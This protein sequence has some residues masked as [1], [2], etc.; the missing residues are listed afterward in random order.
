MNKK[1]IL[2]CLIFVFGFSGFAQ[3]TIAKIK[4]EEAEESYEKQDYDITLNRLNEAESILGSSNPKTQYLR[5]LAQNKL[6]Q[7]DAS[8]SYELLEDL[9]KNCKAYIT[10]YGDNP[11]ME[12]KFRDVYKIAE[13]LKIYPDSRQEFENYVT[14]LKKEAADKEQKYLRV[15][16]FA[17]SLS[18]Q[19]KFK[20]NLNISEFLQLNQE[21]ASMELRQ[22]PSDVFG[23]PSISHNPV[24][25]YRKIKNVYVTG[26]T[27]IIEDESGKVVCYGEY[28]GND[29]GTYEENKSVYIRMKE[30]ILINIASEFI[31]IKEKTDGQLER[32]RIIISV[33]SNKKMDVIEYY[34][35]FDLLKYGSLAQNI[36]LHFITQK[37]LKAY[38]E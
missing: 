22:Y 19:Y 27:G 32:T 2:I 6:V 3:N 11:G 38:S 8:Q 16:A 21:L 12:E 5:I 34:I 10:A 17:D 35:V 29:K 1:I 4:Y 36:G 37:M 7:K 23:F 13:N 14:A 26:F 30:T 18:T 20:P 28:I 15:L 31:Q 24:R 25:D 33:P 9:R